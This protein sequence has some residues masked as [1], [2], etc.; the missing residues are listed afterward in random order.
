MKA[1]KVCK[2]K[3]S[4]FKKII[5]MFICFEGIAGAGKT[6]QV[7]ILEKY[8]ESKKIKILDIEEFGIA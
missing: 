4:I 6:T 5:I 1:Y 7:K 3:H 2:D 8:L